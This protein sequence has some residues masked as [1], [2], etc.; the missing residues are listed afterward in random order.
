M[1]SYFTIL[2]PLTLTCVRLPDS[3][4]QTDMSTAVRRLCKFHMTGD[5]TAFC[6][7]HSTLMDILRKRAS[8]NLQPSLKSTRVADERLSLMQGMLALE[9]IVAKL[10][11][12]ENG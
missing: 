10:E 7:T 3:T 2:W 5:V 4:G 11:A 6:K 9:E 1:N 12:S 8:A